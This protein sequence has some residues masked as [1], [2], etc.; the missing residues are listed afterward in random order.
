MRAMAHLGFSN[1]LQAALSK[2]GSIE[3][4][5]GGRSG[6]NS[7]CHLANRPRYRIRRLL[8]G[9]ISS[10]EG[11]ELSSRASQ[12][13]AALLFDLGTVDIR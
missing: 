5:S 9:D 4:V 7:L 10:T 11:S 8:S 1:F 6:S 12:N 13:A 2:A 3:T